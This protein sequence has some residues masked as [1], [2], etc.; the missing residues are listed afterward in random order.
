MEI[1]IMSSEPK[2]A[3]FL[4]NAVLTYSQQKYV[5]IRVSVFRNM[6]EYLLAS[7]H[8]GMIFID[9]N[10]ELKSSVENAKIVRSK[11][12]KAAL[13]LLSGNPERV[14]EAFSVRTHRFLMKPVTRSD[15]FEA[16]DAY[17]KDLYTYRIIIAKVEDAFRVFSSEE[18]YALIAEGN[19]TRILT[20][21]EE[22]EVFTGFSQIEAQLPEEYF[23][24]CHRAFV[25]NMKH[26]AR[27]EPE[28]IELTNHAV[29][30]VSRRRKLDFFVRYS[31]FVKGHTFSD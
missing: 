5:D 4:K 25:V 28:Q 22:V 16:I 24:K 1:F 19:H 11:D 18:I 27:L 31:E 7:E 21:E 9:D 2:T 3:R 20:K 10:F 8:P 30:P 6:R 23:Y 14:F 13:V 17:R 29:L 12:A 26:I 15:I